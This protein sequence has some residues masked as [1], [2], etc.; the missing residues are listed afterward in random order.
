MKNLLKDEAH[1]KKVQDKDSSEYKKLIKLLHQISKA[2][3]EL[4]ERREDLPVH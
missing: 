4:R 3:A 1:N 2:K